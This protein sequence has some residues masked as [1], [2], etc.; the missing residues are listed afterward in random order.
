[1]QPHHGYDNALN[2]NH[3]S[4]VCNFSLKDMKKARTPGFHTYK[5]EKNLI[6]YYHLGK[7]IDTQDITMSLK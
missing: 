7:Y 1:M 3:Q 2:S 5:K 4:L 6:C